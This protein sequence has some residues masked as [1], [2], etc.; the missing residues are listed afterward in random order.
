MFETE[1]RPFVCLTARV[2][3]TTLKPGNRLEV[4]EQYLQVLLSHYKEARRGLETESLGSELESLVR[5]H[6]KKQLVAE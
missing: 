5:N 6:N 2:K 3:G 1:A 4:S